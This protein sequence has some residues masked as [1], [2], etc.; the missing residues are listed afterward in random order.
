MDRLCGSIGLL[1]D[2]G[3]IADPG[4]SRGEPQTGRRWARPTLRICGK[5]S[6]PSGHRTARTELPRPGLDS[7]GIKE[8][9]HSHAGIL[10]DF[11]NFGTYDRYDA[12]RKTLPHA[13][14][15]Y[16]AY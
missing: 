6:R 15:V 5:D 4:R 16:A 11:N 13:P 10:P 7:F 2:P 3:S 1:R 14:A 8:L 9:N 12:V